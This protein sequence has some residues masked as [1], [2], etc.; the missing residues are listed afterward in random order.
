MEIKEE[1]PYGERGGTH[2][3]ESRA[4]GPGVETQCYYCN[5]LHTFKHKAAW[6]QNGQTSTSTCAYTHTRTHSTYAH[7]IYVVCVCLCVYIALTH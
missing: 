6:I 3:R 5:Q 4:K 2:G 1:I 7:N